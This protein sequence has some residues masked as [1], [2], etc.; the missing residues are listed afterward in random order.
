MIRL[1][2]SLDAGPLAVGT[3]NEHFD[4]LRLV[5][6]DGVA[7]LAEALAVPCS[8]KGLRCRLEQ[9]PAGAAAVMRRLP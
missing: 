1:S 4:A 9:T 7:Q 8:Q 2:P 6:W 3:T 5:P